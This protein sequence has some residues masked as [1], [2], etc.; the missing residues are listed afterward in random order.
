[1]T[2]RNERPG[3]SPGPEC[4]TT[5]SF[6]DHGIE[7]GSRLVR[8]TYYRL[9][10]AGYSEFEP[11]EA[12]LDRLE[13]AFVW[14]YLGSADEPGIAAPVEAAIDDARALTR[15]EFVGRPDADLRTA[16]VPAFYRYAARYHCRYRA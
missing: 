14:A 10:E 11:T 1:M 12:F 2:H 15:E 3:E 5:K 16:V 13:S 6:S 7:D 4:T 8:E 9:H